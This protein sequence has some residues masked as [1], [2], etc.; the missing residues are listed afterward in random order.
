MTVVNIYK[1]TVGAD[2]ILVSM[3]KSLCPFNML[4]ITLFSVEFFLSLFFPD[5]V[6]VLCRTNKLTE[7]RVKSITLRGLLF[8]WQ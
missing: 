4:L 1:I 8:S 5:Y 2:H 3:A 6:W 7:I